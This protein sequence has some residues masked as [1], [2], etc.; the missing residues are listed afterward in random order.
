[1]RTIMLHEGARA[2]GGLQ[3]RERARMTPNLNAA[4]DEGRAIGAAQY[5]EAQAARTEAIAFFTR[6]LAGFDA[7]LAPS[8]PGP[9]PRGITTTGDP[10]CCTLWSLL[11][12]PALSLPAGLVDGL[13]VGLQIA[14]PQG[15]DDQVLSVASWC[16]ARMPFATLA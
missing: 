4:L 1:M 3:S 12:F 8:A 7:V 9:A 16:A 11:G 6:W 13:P 10:S 14:A 2:L 15:R 5:R